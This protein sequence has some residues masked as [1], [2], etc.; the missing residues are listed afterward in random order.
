MGFISGIAVMATPR[1]SAG[2]R[3]V[4]AGAEPHAVASSHLD[5]WASPT[6]KPQFTWRAT[7][8]GKN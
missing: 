4:P 3:V 5:L 7:I 1:L 2:Q 6:R 8:K